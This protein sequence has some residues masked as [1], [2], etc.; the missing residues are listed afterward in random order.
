M[1]DVI[2][3]LKENPVGGFA[4]VSDNKPNVRPFQFMLE[5]K[6]KL[7][8]CTSNKKNVCKEIQNNPYVAFTSYAQNTKY[9]RINGKIK[10]INE[11]GIKE[12]VLN[13]NQIVKTIYKS[14]SNPDFE[15]FFFESGNIIFAD[16]LGNP[17]KEFNI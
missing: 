15:V 11:T 1:K 6:G 9:V 2:E 8:F 13:S 12:K 10:F 14:G 7:F 4:T 17:R 3:F 16:L 5:E